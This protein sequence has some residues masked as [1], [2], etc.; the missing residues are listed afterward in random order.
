[1]R[2]QLP[3]AA[4][5]KFCKEKARWAVA[6]SIS[7]KRLIAVAV[8][9]AFLALGASAH[10]TQFVVNGDFTELSNGVGQPDYNTVVTG[11]TNT[12]PG[13]G[14]SYN[15]VMTSA[16]A[17]A[18]GTSGT[19]TLWDA[20][21]GGAN[22]WD[23]SA[24]GPGNFIAMDGDYYT[25]SIQQVITGLTVGDYYKLSFNYAFGQQAGFTGATQQ[26]LTYSLGGASGQT[27]TFSVASQG[28]T[29]WQTLTTDIKAT[30]SSE[31]LSFLANGNLPVPPFALV[32]N[33]SLT[34]PEPASWALMMIGFGALGAMARRRRAVSLVAA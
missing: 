33:V 22:S 12:T 14:P 28:F 20:N 25:G 6:R 19:V 27:S 11:W 32:S 16:S 3:V 2:I 23:G 1:V 17:G 15:F 24:A 34:A 10:A 29:G 4:R 7:M 18:S 13:P 5:L 21:N 31:V 9:S 8:T 30:S 26:Y